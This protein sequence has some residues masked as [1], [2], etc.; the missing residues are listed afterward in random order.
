MNDSLMKARAAR[1]GAP[2]LRA[3]INDK[4]KSCGYD[5]EAGMGAWRQQIEACTVKS[6]PL[7]IVRPISKSGKD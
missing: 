5:T 4:C 1:K 3:A 2:S 6:C 7:W